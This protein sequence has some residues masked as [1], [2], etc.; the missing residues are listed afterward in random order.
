MSSNFSQI[1]RKRERKTRKRYSYICMEFK[2][3]TFV[4]NLAYY[5]IFPIAD[6]RKHAYI[7]WT[8]YNTINLELTTLELYELNQNSNSKI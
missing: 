8:R 4:N 3:I 1:L 2:H 7:S 6:I 5:V